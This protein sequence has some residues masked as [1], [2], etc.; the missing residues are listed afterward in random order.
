MRFPWFSAKASLFAVVRDS[1]GTGHAEV[2]VPTTHTRATFEHDNDP[3]DVRR[4]FLQI[5]VLQMY[6]SG[7]I[8]REEVCNGLTLR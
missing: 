1:P 2:S 8:L 6:T 5:A 7:W 3:H 4:I